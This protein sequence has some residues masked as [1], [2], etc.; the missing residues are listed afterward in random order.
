MPLWR[1]CVLYQVGL[2][3]ATTVAACSDH[4][5]L[6]FGLQCDGKGESVRQTATSRSGLTKLNPFASCSTVLFESATLHNDRSSVSPTVVRRHSKWTIAFGW[7][8]LMHRVFVSYRRQDSAHETD[9]IRERLASTLGSRAVFTDTHSI[10]VGENFRQHIDR[11]L[12]RCDVLLVVI[13]WR[14]LNARNGQGEARLHQE[15]DPVRLEIE[16]AFS[17]GIPVIP[18]LVGNA[19]VPRADELPVSIS[20]LSSI[21]G[22]PLR[23]DP[24]FGQDIKRLIGAVKTAGGLS[25]LQRIRNSPARWV[26]HA[27]STIGK[28]LVAGAASYP[29]GVVISAI[30]TMPFSIPPYDWRSV[31]L[32][33]LPTLLGVALLRR[34]S[35]VELVAILACSYFVTYWLY[36]LIFSFA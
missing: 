23:P 18:V 5:S 11:A 16:L 8:P 22:I 10:P 29:V 27:L 32:V 9:R 19:I 17:R 35:W 34:R 25:V 21:N 6:W 7:S 28:I 31:T 36:A 26:L 13:G 1:C 14:W 20:E 12:S 24:Y 2:N 33:V 15:D 4:Y 30:G 3:A